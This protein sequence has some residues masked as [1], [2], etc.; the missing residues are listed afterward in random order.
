MD[1]RCRPGNCGRTCHV[2]FRA[3]TAGGVKNGPDNAYFL[4]SRSRTSTSPS[5][6]AENWL[7]AKMP[8]PAMTS[9]DEDQGER[10]GRAYVAAIAQT[11]LDNMNLRRQKDLFRKVL[12]AVFV[13]A[14][15][16]G[17][18]ATRAMVQPCPTE[19][20]LS[21]HHTGHDETFSHP[22]ESGNDKACCASVCATFILIIPTSDS[23]SMHQTL[24]IA[25]FAELPDNLSGRM[26]SPAF[27][28]PRPAA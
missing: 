7:P 20:V 15:F 22:V 17:T 23:D 14:M 13:L 21:S 18:P 27:E 11:G 2:T 16:F 25:R 1:G 28:P 9:I 19:H 4:S 5:T 24:M 8:D 6:S 12:A 3:Q 26:P 10:S